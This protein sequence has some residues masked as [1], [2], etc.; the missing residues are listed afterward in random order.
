MSLMGID[1]GTTGC[2]VVV[3]NKEGKIISWAYTEYDIKH[4][5][6]GFAELDSAEVWK[7]IKTIIRQ[8]S[9]QISSSDPVEAISTSSLGE[10]VVPVSADRTILGSSILI[11]DVRGSEYLEDIRNKISNK[12]CFQIT[13]N[14]I[15]SQFGI[16][17][18]I[19]IKEHQPELYKKTWKFLNWGSFIAFMLGAEPCVDYSLANRFLLFDLNLHTWSSRLLLV[20]DLDIDKLPRCVPAGTVI[21]TVSSSI[22]ADLSL[23]SGIPIICGTHDQIA[24]G[25]GSG[26]IRPGEAMYDMGTFST[27]MPIHNGNLFP[28]KMISYGLNIEH[29]VIP[30]IF[31]SFI[32]NM[33]GS[34]VKWYR[35]TFA[36]AE[37][38]ISKEQGEDIY[39]KLFSEIPEGPSTIFVLPNFAPMGPPDF[40]SDSSGIILGLKNFTLRGEILKAI[41]EANVFALKISVDNIKSLGVQIN[42]YK[43]VGGGSKSEKAIQICADILGCPL[44]CPDII[45]AGALGA[46]IL[47]GT[48]CGIYDSLEEASKQFVHVRKIIMPNKEKTFIYNEMFEFY[49]HLSHN[50]IELTYEW[51][52]LRKKILS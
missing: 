52:A 40:L 22:A 51:N 27:I 26:T 44:E 35:D 42:S 46:A 34:I 29:H 18:L 2:K 28:E 17:K 50:M 20:A 47:A 39:L 36:S 15:G 21:G 32:Y 4:T 38:K 41:L 30:G 37:F 3:F 23:P 43:A 24:H 14:A 7:V 19:W 31:V 9:F 49:K 13:G 1:I 25:L 8:A 16:T 45:E 33:G 5:D 12:E 6:S 48:G 10:A 11:N